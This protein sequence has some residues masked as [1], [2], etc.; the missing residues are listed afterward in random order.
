MTF[1]LK[2]FNEF[3]VKEGLELNSFETI[4]EM[5]SYA[6][7]RRKNLFQKEITYSLN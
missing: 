1:P 2:E 5:L 4:E 6:K 3:I 7:E